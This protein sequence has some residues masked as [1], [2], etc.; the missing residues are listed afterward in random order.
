ML[1]FYGSWSLYF[2]ALLWEIYLLF[3]VV[4]LLITKLIDQSN[5][6][7]LVELKILTYVSTCLT[8]LMF[9]VQLVFLLINFTHWIYLKFFKKPSAHQK[10][11]NPLQPQSANWS[12]ISINSWTTQN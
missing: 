8:I 7:Q 10:P 5:A 9:L 6:N 2:Q 11:P 12:T 1:K 3:I 4:L